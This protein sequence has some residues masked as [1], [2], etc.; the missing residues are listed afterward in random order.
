MNC[1]TPKE[2]REMKIKK[3]INQNEWARMYKAL[4]NL[5]VLKDQLDHLDRDSEE[6]LTLK[7]IPGIMRV[8]KE[9][10]EILKDLKAAFENLN[11]HFTI[12]VVPEFLEDNDLASIASK[13]H[14]VDVRNQMRVTAEK[15]EKENLLQ[16][17]K[18]NGYPDMVKEGV[19][20]VTLKSFVKTAMDE[21]TPYPAEMINIDPYRQA[22][23]VKK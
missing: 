9:A 6:D 2:T 11:T 16:W 23:L 17:L 8:L 20:A 1:Q 18:D 12:N 19:N 21:G 10:K 13:D 7:S 15:S 4:D 14:R 3:A 22:V 5:N